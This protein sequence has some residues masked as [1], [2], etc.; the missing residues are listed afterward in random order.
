MLVKHFHRFLAHPKKMYVKEEFTFSWY[1]QKVE[2]KNECEVVS[3]RLITKTHR[4]LKI[5]AHCI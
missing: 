2:V 3:Y 1:Y 4:R 5:D